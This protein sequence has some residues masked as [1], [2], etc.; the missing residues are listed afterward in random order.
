M[1]WS[2]NK[3]DDPPIPSTL[4]KDNLVLVA[5]SF[6]VALSN[7]TDEG[8]RHLIGPQTQGDL[9]HT[10][11]LNLK[12]LSVAVDAKLA[13]IQAFILDPVGP[14]IQDLK[15]TKNDPESPGITYGGGHHRYI[16]EYFCRV[17]LIPALRLYFLQV[18]PYLK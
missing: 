13:C 16:V 9:L 14:L 4:S 6:L 5:S 10:P 17:F 7:A 18:H 12:F 8:K 1:E 15:V 3:G 2:D 11:G